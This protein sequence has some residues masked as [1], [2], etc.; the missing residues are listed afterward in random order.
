[1]ISTYYLVIYFNNHSVYCRKK[2]YYKNVKFPNDL[3]VI[4]IHLIYL[5]V[6][7]K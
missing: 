5:D 1:M 7:L 2:N 4:K 6:L 3:K